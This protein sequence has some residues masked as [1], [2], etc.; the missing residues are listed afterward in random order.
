[1]EKEHVPTKEERKP[2]EDILDGLGEKL[3]PSGYGI[4]WDDITEAHATPCS[5]KGFMLAP[6]V[7]SKE[8]VCKPV[9]VVTNPIRVYRHNKVE[10]EF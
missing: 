4:F 2:I 8:C 9:L 7:G 10:G 6:H 5:G 1:M 3:R